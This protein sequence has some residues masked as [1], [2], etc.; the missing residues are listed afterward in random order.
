MK[1]KRLVVAAAACC[2]AATLT[3]GCGSFSRD[4]AYKS[5]YSVTTLKSAD[6]MEDGG[7]YVKHTDG[8]YDKL[9]VGKATFS[10]SDSSPSEDDSHVLWFGKDYD[11]I[12]TMLKGESIV[13]HNTKE[14]SGGVTIERFEDL[15]YTIGIAGLTRTSTG[16]FS[17]STDTD[18]LNIDLSSDAGGL[19]QLGD[20]T[21][22]L[23]KIGS[24]PLRSGNVSRAGTILGLT[25]GK[26]YAAYLYIGTELKEYNLVADVR[27]MA[28]M[29]GAT[30]TDYTYAADNVTQFK[31]PSNYQSGY[32]LVDGYGVVRY[33]ASGDGYKESMDMNIPNAASADSDSTAD[34]GT[35]SGTEEQPVDEITKDT[36][37]MDFK[38][39]ENAN[40]TVE[41]TYTDDT[42]S[43]DS[44]S[45]SGTPTAKVI[46]D[47]GVY[48][49]N[50]DKKSGKLTVTAD[51]HAGSYRLQVIG[52]AG[53]KC[54]YR[55]MKNKALDSDAT[56]SG[57]TI[58]Y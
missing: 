23:D 7:Y 40:V 50:S 30:L 21:V 28:S 13:Y 49:L 10:L 19:Y 51:M 43:T 33:I 16:R 58:H 6:E 2:L 26:T 25:R 3:T 8:S 18:D 42:D 20:H 48:T 12:P 52:L 34:S 53:R 22:V 24:T 1:K 37:E 57:K 54:S 15:G 27:A 38:L 14:F 41:L 4:Y 46:S 45:G 44:T 32:Y 11:C 31:F 47:Y 55:V 17:F 35:D 36:R 39:D 56:D 5:S 9:Y 29:D